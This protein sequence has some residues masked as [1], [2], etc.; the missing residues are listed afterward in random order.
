MLTLRRA[1]FAAHYVIMNVGA[2]L[3]QPIV[4]GFRLGLAPYSG[5][6][7]LLNRPLWSFFLLC[8]CVLH[9]VSLFFVWKWIRDIEVMEPPQDR[10]LAA[11]EREQERWPVQSVSYNK[12]ETWR[13]F[14]RRMWKIFRGGMLWRFVVLSLSLVG[15]KSVFVYLI[16]L[17]PVYMKRA[18]FP[19]EHP[20]QVPF[21]TFLIINP[22][23]V[24]AV[25]YP[26]GAL[27][28]YMGWDRFWVSH[29]TQWSDLGHTHHPFCRSLSWAPP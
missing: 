29:E 15:A 24:I 18:P 8:N 26:F 21:M 27:V 12:K 19:V 9:V 5:T 13:E 4:D 7:W 11:S 14:K 20:E 22:I 1:A 16:S 10:P 2:A 17:Y 28:T 6:P 25:T 23:I 3:S